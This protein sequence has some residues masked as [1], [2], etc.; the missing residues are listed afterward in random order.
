MLTCSTNMPP[1]G[2]ER[3][4]LDRSLVHALPGLA[5]A[6]VD[7]RHDNFRV[8]AVAVLERDVQ[9]RVE[10]AVA[11]EVRLEAEVEKACVLGVVVVVVLLDARV[12]DVLYPGL[13]AQLVRRV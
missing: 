1:L 2:L 9:E 7:G 10:Q 11:Q 3:R 4:G 8:Y 6:P 12:L 13:D 5:L